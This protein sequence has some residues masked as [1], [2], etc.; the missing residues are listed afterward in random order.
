MVLEPN[1]F[2][3]MAERDVQGEVSILPDHPRSNLSSVAAAVNDYKDNMNA[4][5]SDSI[6]SPRMEYRNQAS[7][8]AYR[9]RS[10]RGRVYY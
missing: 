7:R 10:G 9:P 1:K 6:S 3:K 2:V 5:R 4:R 8:T